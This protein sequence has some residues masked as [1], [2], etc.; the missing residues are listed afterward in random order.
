MGKEGEAIAKERARRGSNGL[1]HVPEGAAMR[2]L[3]ACHQEDTATEPKSPS[4]SDAWRLKQ[5]ELSTNAS[6]E[7]D[8]SRF[9]DSDSGEASGSGAFPA[10]AL[11]GRRCTPQ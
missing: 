3:A 7:D 8:T 10:S 6:E 1:V 2:H 9:S 11:P 4:N 5:D